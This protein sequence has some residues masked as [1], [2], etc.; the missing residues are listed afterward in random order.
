MKSLLHN[1]A[2]WSFYFGVVLFFIIGVAVM[3][4]SFPVGIGIVVIGQICSLITCFVL[5][6][7]E[8]KFKQK[9][10]RSAS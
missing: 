6:K 2:G 8:L 10:E 4:T 3:F 5:Y 9:Q 1:M 7:I